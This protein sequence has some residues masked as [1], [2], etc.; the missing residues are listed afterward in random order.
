LPGIV[1][2]AATMIGFKQIEFHRALAVA[3]RNVLDYD[4]MLATL[5]SPWRVA[6]VG[7]D[8]HRGTKS[9]RRWGKRS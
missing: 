7:G 6:K 2:S 9:Q 4:P 1:R 5:H 8:S 3:P